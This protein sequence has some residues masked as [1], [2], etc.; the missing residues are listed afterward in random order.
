[1]QLLDEPMLPSL[2]LVLGLRAGV[3]LVPCLNLSACIP[4]ILGTNALPRLPNLL[5]RLLFDIELI[6]VR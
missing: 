6:A 2:C 3:R 4:G 1:L 5:C